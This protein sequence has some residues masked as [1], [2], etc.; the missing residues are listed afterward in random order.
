MGNTI[1][2]HLKTGKFYVV[3]CKAQLEK[4]QTPMI[5]YRSLSTGRIWIRPEAEFM[6]GRF[7]EMTYD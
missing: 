7:K 5:V 1:W 4:D 2:I 3:V 6:D